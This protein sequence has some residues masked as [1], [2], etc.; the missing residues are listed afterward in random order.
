MATRI[1][2]EYGKLSQATTRLRTSCINCHNLNVE[3]LPPQK[4]KRAKYSCKKYGLKFNFSGYGN[5]NQYLNHEKGCPVVEI[6]HD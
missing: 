5:Y 1:K 6:W 4:K 3:L 2:Y